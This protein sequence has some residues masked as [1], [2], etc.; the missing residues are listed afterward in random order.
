MLEMATVMTVPTNN[1]VI[2]MEATVVELTS[3]LNIVLIVNA[4]KNENS[5]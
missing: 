5:E 4:N 2:M 1:Y 3:L